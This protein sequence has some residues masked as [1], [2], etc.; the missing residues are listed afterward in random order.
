MTSETERPDGPEIGGCKLGSVLGRGGMGTVYRAT[1]LALARE[2]AVK[3]VPASGAADAD[4]ARFQREARIAARL[5]HPN[6]VP[7]YAAGEQDGVLYLVMKL[8]QGPN[9][10]ALVAREGPLTPE[11]AVELLSQV[12]EAL[13]A[14]HAAGLV[15]RDVKPSNVLIEL[16]RDA[17]RAYLSDFGLMRQVVDERE[18]TGANEWVG[19]IDYASPEQLSG[20]A[21]DRRADVY[22]LAGV[23]Y[24][25]LSGQRPYPRDSATATAW[26]HL[27]VMPPSLGGH[28]LDRVIARGMAKRPEDRYASAGELARAARAAL[29]PPAEPTVRLPVA[30]RQTRTPSRRAAVAGV[31]AVAIV[32]VIGIVLAISLGP[33]GASARKH[34]GS[35]QIDVAAFRVTIPSGW[36]VME[37]DRQMGAF[38]RTEAVDPTGSELVIIDRDP[39]EPLAPTAWGQSVEQETSASTGYRRVSFAGSTI[40]GRQALVWKFLL[41][42]DPLRA[43]VDVFQQMPSNGFAVLGEAS[44]VH[45]A[46][47]IALSV[48]RSLSQR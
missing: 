42:R 21:I 40:S 4:V 29:A 1:Q 43:R 14:A 5:E 2:V 9:L 16:R 34:G 17:D 15:H 39:G 13:D 3:V 32:A 25:A 31:L 10:G 11:R 45:A 37:I 19:T 12:A 46:T 35:T 44:S 48:A 24:T 28:P 23:L 26:A 47:K 6:C 38:E 30:A 20:R 41:R 18:I 27:N 8:V 7:I 33:G 22:A 36:Q